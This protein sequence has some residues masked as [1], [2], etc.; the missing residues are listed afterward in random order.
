MR[1]RKVVS[2]SCGPIEER[3]EV[4]LEGDQRG[5]H[6]VV[7]Y[8]TFDGVPLESIELT[9][10]R[11]GLVVPVPEFR[12]DIAFVAYSEEPRGL[13]PL[14]ERTPTPIHDHFD[15]LV[16]AVGAPPRPTPP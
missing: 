12:H 3:I 4:I 1:D 10:T 5:K 15:R 9:G 6:T 8:D 14:P 2:Y 13:I 7:F 11:E 16:K